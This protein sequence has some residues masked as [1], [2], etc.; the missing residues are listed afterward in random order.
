MK[1]GE[2][3]AKVYEPSGVEKRIYKNWED[4]GYF[5][6]VVTGVSD[7]CIFV[8]IDKYDRDLR[9][10]KKRHDV[11]SHLIPISSPRRNPVKS[12]I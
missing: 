7:D 8:K 11:A 9:I 12:S 1:K 6:G 5:K 2:N 3:M 4:K 10:D